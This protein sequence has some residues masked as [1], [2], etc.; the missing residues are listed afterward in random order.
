MNPRGKKLGEILIEKRII[1]ETQLKIALDEQK[2][3]GEFLGKCL[4]AHGWATEEQVIQALSE[5]FGIPYIQI[6]P[7]DVQWEVAGQYPSAVFTEHHCFPIRQDT[8]SVTL[9]ISDPLNAWVMS[10]IQT[11][12][13]GRAV[14]LVLAVPSQIEK[15]IDEYT[16]RIAGAK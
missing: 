16:R 8:V 4:M 5:Q 11:H 6:R 15:I 13:R 12:A 7:G 14:K 9:A 3:S 2:Q 10:E 1:N